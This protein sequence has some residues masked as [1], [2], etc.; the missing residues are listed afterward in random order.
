MSDSFSD[1]VAAQHRFFSTEQTLSPAFRIA[2]L[3]KLRRVIQDAE[4]EI[5]LALQKDLGKNAFEAVTS[6]IGIVLGEIRSAL[7]LIRKYATWRRVP[8]PLFLWPS[9]SAVQY[10]PLG[11]CL[12]IAP[13]NYPFQLAL[14]PLVGAIAAGNCAVV[15]P[16]ERSVHTSQVIARILA[17]AFLPEHVQTVIAD[18]HESAALLRQPFDKLFFTG[19]RTVGQIVYREAAEK[20]VPCTLELGGKNPCIV[21]DDADIAMAARRIVWGKFYNAG[22]TCVAPD[23]LLVHTSVAAPL[24]K[25]IVAEIRTRFGQ[26]PADCPHYGRLI[27]GVH[28]NGLRALLRGTSPLCGGEFREEDHFLSPTVVEADWD[29]PLMADEIFGPVLPVL[30]FDDLDHALEKI[31]GL[32]K[33]LALYV[34]TRTRTTAKRIFRT[35]S[36]GGGCINDTLVHFSSPYL[37]VGGVGQ[38]GTGRYRGMD[39]FRAF[40][41]IKAVVET[42]GFPDLKLR[43]PPFGAARLRLVKKLMK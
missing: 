29:H 39:G 32:P 20:M 36:F 40:S 42:P 18:R 25:A 3:K 28:L 43:Y 7:K 10:E 26:S 27:D 6:E 13:W 14:A 41:N 21:M 8:T 33:S 5:F 9:R 35:L 24:Q 22:Q 2:A 11:V 30:P 17:R 19:S 1:M 31:R 34:F 16:S 15:K 4:E 38:S 37:S 12:I 23:Y